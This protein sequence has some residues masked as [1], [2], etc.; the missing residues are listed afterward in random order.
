MPRTGLALAALAIGLLLAGAAAAAD[1]PAW[2]SSSFSPAAVVMSFTRAVAAGAGSGELRGFIAEG[3]TPQIAAIKGPLLGWR[4]AKVFPTKGQRNG[5][6]VILEIH[7]ASP[8][9]L[10]DWSR[11]KVTVRQEGIGWK[12]VAIAPFTE[13]YYGLDESVCGSRLDWQTPSYATPQAA[14]CTYCWSVYDNR[15]SEYAKATGAKGMLFSHGDWLEGCSFS[16]LDSDQTE[17]ETLESSPW[18]DSRGMAHVHMEVYG[19]DNTEALLVTMQRSDFLWEIAS[20]KL[21]NRK[22]MKKNK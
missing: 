5:H 9:Y 17:W 3:E 19:Y 20:W 6:A 4:I 21:L 11:Y 13:Q 14:L 7:D 12:I 10:A 8:G 15:M 22:I 16:V 2:K 18:S 1:G